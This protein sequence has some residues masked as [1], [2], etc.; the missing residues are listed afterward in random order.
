M[1]EMSG[2]TY[3][4]VHCEDLGLYYIPTKENL[5]FSDPDYEVY[6][7]GIDWR[8]GGVYFTS[9]AKIRTFTLKCYFEEIDVKR[10]QAIKE[11]VHRDSSGLLVFDDMP[12]I[13]W[14]VRPGKIPAGNWYLD[15]NES[16]SGTVTLT[17]NAYEP[18]GY[19]TRKYNN[20]QNDH[21]EDYCNL[22]DAGDMPDA[23]ETSDTSFEV[24]NPGTE[25][26]GLSIEIAGSC[27]NHF[28]F[29]NE[30]NGTFCD[31]NSIPAG[32][33]RL[34]IDGE[35]GY[36]DTHVAN[37]S[38]KENGFAYHEKGVVRLEPNAGRSGVSF[39][40]GTTSGTE[41]QMDLVGYPVTQAIRGATVTIGNDIVLTVS[42][43]STA[44]NRI[45]CT[46]ESAVTMPTSGTCSIKTINKIRIEEK[47]GD[48]WVTP[49]TLSLSYIGIDYRPRAM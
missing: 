1:P 31:F 23:P 39:V 17:F 48:S 41:Y 7:E 38:S 18:F 16:H 44:N 24:Y 26:C 14:N 30:T 4:G 28:R 47:P 12:F 22:I 40:N 20:G 25:T 19:L 29:F 27:S 35:T 15:S 3:N 32:G 9:K 10:R 6:D 43:I 46:S 8:H 13:Y 49:T 34:A 5:W 33:L 37:S 36:V 42:S 2:F 45:W 11:W 21:S